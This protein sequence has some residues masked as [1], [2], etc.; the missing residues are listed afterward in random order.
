[1]IKQVTEQASREKVISD[2]TVSHRLVGYLL[3]AGTTALRGEWGR[4][5]ALAY[6]RPAVRRLKGYAFDPQ[7]SV[8]LATAMINDFVIELPWEQRWE[9]PLE[10]GP[11][12]D[13]VEVVDFDPAAGLFYA[14][15]DLNHPDL[16]AQNG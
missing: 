15:I 5:M 4:Y 9:S 10:V 3:R 13:Y 14:P 16:L 2:L 8:T 7:A 1:M 6:P 12:N 11:V